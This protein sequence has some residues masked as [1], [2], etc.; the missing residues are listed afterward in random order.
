MGL[1]PI[2]II[3][4]L[5]LYKESR[6]VIDWSS[7][8]AVNG[9]VCHSAVPIPVS[10]TAP[11]VISSDTTLTLVLNMLIKGSRYSSRRLSYY[12]LIPKSMHHSEGSRCLNSS[13]MDA[14]NVRL[15]GI[16]LPTAHRIASRVKAEAVDQEKEKL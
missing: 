16:I 8:S 1:G 5:Q 15:P 2:G 12:G 13:H 11:G 6:A 14:C 4:V 10:G 9:I 3:R 7:L